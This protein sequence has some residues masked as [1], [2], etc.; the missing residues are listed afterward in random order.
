MP[1]DFRNRILRTRNLSKLRFHN[2][3]FGTE[4]FDVVIDLE[5]DS[6]EDQFEFPSE[7]T[8]S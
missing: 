7:N 5:F 8:I 3:Y 4:K 1:V 2:D 6:C